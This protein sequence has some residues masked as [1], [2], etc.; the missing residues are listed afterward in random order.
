MRLRQKNGLSN[1]PVE[2]PTKSEKQIVKENCLTFFNMIFIVLAVCLALVGAFG[3]ML[4]LFIAIAN[5]AI[6]IFQE[7][8]SKRTIDKLT[9]MTA[10]KVPATRGRQEGPG[11]LGPAGPGRH[12]GVRRRRP[13]LRRRGGR[14][15]RSRS[16]SPSSPARRTPS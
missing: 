16:T 9:L 10:R 4:F 11:A 5:T 7:I 15:A 14:W 3:D 6:G 2:S 13:D 12:R 8:R 1:E